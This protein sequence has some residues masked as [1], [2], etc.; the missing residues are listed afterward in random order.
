MIPLLAILSTL[1]AVFVFVS[2]YFIKALRKSFLVIASYE[3]IYNE[4]LDDI[5]VIIEFLEQL[6]KRELLSTD[7]DFVN[8]NKAVDYAY[9]VLSKY[10]AEST[11]MVRGDVRER[12]EEK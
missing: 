6:D 4:T 11:S 1:L 10:L 8:F 2:L 3:K 5:E 9:N 12:S 7:P